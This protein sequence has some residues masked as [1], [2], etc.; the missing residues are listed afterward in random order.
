[1]TEKYIEPVGNTVFV[2]G[3]PKYITKPVNAGSKQMYIY[4]LVHVVTDPVY[5]DNFIRNAEK[6]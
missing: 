1:M 6:E 5:I 4:K 3:E 2:D